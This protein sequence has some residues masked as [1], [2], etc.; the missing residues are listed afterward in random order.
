MK[1]RFLAMAASLCC[2]MSC[3]KTNTEIGG[4]LIPIDQSYTF[5]TAEIP[6][7]EIEMRMAD[8]LSGYSQTRATIGAI[9]DEVYGLTTRGCVITLVPLFDE[10]L[11]FGTDPQYN[12]FHFAMA[13]DTLNMIDQSLEKIIQ[14]V[15]V[16]ELDEPLNPDKTY[17]C[18]SK[19][20]HGTKRITKSVPVF[21]GGDSLSFDFSKEYGKRYMDITSSD[22]ADFDTY[23]KKFPGI[24]IET[25]EPFGNSGRIDMFNLQL[26]YDS[27]YGYITGN[28]ASL[29]FNAIYDGER[30]DT[31]FYFYYSATDFYDVDSLL[32]NSG[33]GS[34][35]EYC[36]NVT[37]QQTRHNAGW[38]HDKI[39]VEGGG[40]LKP[41]VSAKY[42]K[43]LVENEISANGGIP[44][45]TVISKATLIFP[46]E[47]P[48]DYTEV[49]NIWPA[50]L[51]PTCR[52]IGS[53]ATSF[54]GLTDASSSDENQGDINRS[55]CQYEPDITYH[56][57]ELLKID[58]DDKDARTTTY[59]NNGSYDIWL[60]IM[61]NEEVTTTSSS[62][63]DLS[64]Y[65]QYLAYQSY[66]S[67]MY[68]G[69][70]SGYGYSDYYSNYYNYM[71]MAQYASSSSSST[72][73]QTML[74][75][76]RFYRATLNGP[77]SKN[78]RKPV[79]KIT[80]GIPLKAE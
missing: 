62:S 54:M 58:E 71:L 21:N 35:P 20:A 41:A 1:Y 51:S 69:Y 40:G 55:T 23:L 53:A 79:L 36:L 42:I 64:E 32:T 76:D 56:L 8:S 67:S 24:Y 70:S 30:R 29:S 7:E 48:E 61:A 22:L 33:T 26:D 3:V 63:S 73:Y 10:T 59:L 19:I 38:A 65:Y 4:S 28:C 9:D 49:D 18:N 15:N 74:D 11:D 16:Y 12:N 68:G 37:T 46:F 27:D 31:T 44:S 60:L 6:L 66:Y 34:F 75:K 2:L 14:N 47:F 25:D 17:D 50:V 78:E 43:K 5:Y 77:T 52:V 39:Y 57:Q 45:E 80:Y 13:T 72:S